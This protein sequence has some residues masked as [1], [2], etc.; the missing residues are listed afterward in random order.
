M[1]LLVAEDDPKIGRLI[2]RGLEAESHTVDL[3]TDGAAAL[4]RA[5]SGRYDLL[6]LDLGLPSLDG[7]DLLSRLRRTDEALPVLAVTARGRVEDRVA[8]LDAGADD[9]LV[10]PFSFLELQARVRALFRRREGVATRELRVGALTLDRVR[11]CASRGE[12]TVELSTRE[13]QLLEHLMRHPGQPQTRA[14]LAEQVWGHHFDTGTNVIDVYV[15][16]VRRKLR[17]L[18]LA[19]VQ[20][21]RGIG[22][23]LDPEACEGSP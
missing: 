12:V 4:E 19:P 15:N 20:T 13:F 18:G 14:L 2:Q 11:R 3:V 10:K 17:D 7:V 9:Y 22:Y 5:Q 8:G 21:L 16:Y 6:V 23:V 1:R